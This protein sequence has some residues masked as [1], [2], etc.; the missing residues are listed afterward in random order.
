MT[1]LGGGASAQ[2][3]G[4]ATGGA[5]VAYN[6]V[7]GVGQVYANTGAYGGGSDDSIG[8]AGTATGEAYGGSVAKS[9]VTAI[10]EVGG[11]QAEN[12][13]GYGAGGAANSTSLASAVSAYATSVARGG[14][15]GGPNGSGVGSIGGAAQS[16][17]TAKGGVTGVGK[18]DSTADGGLGG[19]GLSNVG[20]GG[21]G[22]GA[23][24]TASAS[25]KTAYATATAVG[26]QGGGGY[27]RS[28]AA[29]AP[30]AERRPVRPSPAAIAV[31]PRRPSTS[32]AEPA[33]TALS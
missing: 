2:S 5:A 28:T 3:Y 31:T 4:P 11:N 24:V 16:A 13:L 33:A 9:M 30:S 23:D 32:R 21:A 19:P 27:P 25:G 22:G 12:D 8:G 26:G 7:R 20:L 10:G 1:A 17:A 14:Q 29:L 15:G 6:R 18:A